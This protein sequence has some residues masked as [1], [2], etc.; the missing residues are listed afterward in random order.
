MGWK[1]RNEVFEDMAAVRGRDF[2]LTGD[3]EQEKVYAYAVLGSFFPLLGVEPAVGRVLTAEDDQ[4]QDGKVAV[5]SYALWQ[6]RYGGQ[7]SIVG[8]DILLSD[9]RYTVVGVMP[10]GFQFLDPDIRLWVPSGLTPQQLAT[11]GNHYLQVVA[12]M[13]PGV[14]LDQANSDIKTITAQIARDNPDQA[15][16]LDANVISLAEEL[17]GI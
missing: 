7:A 5:I 11:R 17:I 1:A 9:E 8:R 13:K 16:R 10:R 3:G 12:R 14:T 4:P 6:S 2:N 15:S